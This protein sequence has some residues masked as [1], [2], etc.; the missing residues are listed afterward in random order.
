MQNLRFAVTTS[1]RQTADL[2]DAAQQIAAVMKVRYVKRDGRSLA[3]LTA[4]LGLEGWLVVA[5]ERISFVSATGSFF[6]HPG[7]AGLRIKE[8]NR[9]KT[10]Q[11]IKALSVRAG[12]KILDC[13]LGLGTDAIVASYVAGNEGLVVGLEK[14]PLIAYLVQSGLAAYATVDKNVGAAMRRIQVIEADYHDYLRNLPADSF[15]VVYFDPMFRSPRW[16][17]PAIDSLRALAEPAPV[18][19]ETI[20]LAAKIAKECVVLKERRGST[21]FE[22]L[23]FEKTYGGRY[24]PV[25]YGVIG[26]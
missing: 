17:S 6:F 15:D 14:S 12:S 2:V 21:E 13:T 5:A 24:A 22:R 10:D 4:E 7:L 16:S 1:Q 9:G 3:L 8:L 23:G 11:M 19:R 26:Y 20:C 18:D 25:V